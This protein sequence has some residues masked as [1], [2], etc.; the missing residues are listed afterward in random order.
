VAAFR[1]DGRVVAAAVATAVV[2]AVATLGFAGLNGWTAFAAIAWRDLTA[3]QASLAVTAFQ[4]TA[5][6]LRHLLAPD[7]TWNHGAVASLPL[8]ARGLGAALS[9]WVVVVTILVARRGRADL[10]AALAVVASVLALNV[11]QEYTHA[12]LLLPAAVAIGHAI[13]PRSGG[14]LR[15]AWLAVAVAL[16]AAPLPYRDPRLEEGW[17]ALLAYPRLYGAWLLWAW[18][19]RELSLDRRAAQREVAPTR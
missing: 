5:G 13:E 12:L 4:S 6:F 18:L 7:A 2:L 19:V 16:L 9:I 15:T 8:L 3:D 11:A 10:A 1:R 17:L 14:R